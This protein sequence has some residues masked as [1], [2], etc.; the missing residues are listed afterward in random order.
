MLYTFVTE[1][2]GGTYIS[3]IRAKSPDDALSLSV[4]TLGNLLGTDIEFAAS[5]KASPITGRVGVWCATAL[6]SSEKLIL[7][8][9]IQTSECSAVV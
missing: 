1:Y 6:D 2:L 4:C 7:M 3:Q 5:D 8:H 9:I